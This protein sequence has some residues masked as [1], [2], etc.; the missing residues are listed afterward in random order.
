MKNFLI[1]TATAVVYVIL[2][3]GCTILGPTSAY[4]FFSLVAMACT[5]EFCNLMNRQY[6]AAI[7]TPIVAF[8]SVLLS[9]TM[10]LSITSQSAAND[11]HMLVL[12]GI[13]ILFLLIG[14]LYRQ[15][16]NPL[17]NWSLSLASQFYVALPFAMLP[18]IAV[19]YDAYLGTPE[20]EWIY[21]LAL[22]I[23]L[24]MSDTGAYLVGSLLGRY[25]PYKLFPRISPNK[26]W[27]GSIGGAILTLLAA[28]I[29]YNIRPADHSLFEWIGF[30]LVVVCFGTW[31]DLVESLLKRQLGIK[32]SGNALPGH[33]G[34]LDRF[35][36][37]LLAIPA[38]VLY[39]LA[40]A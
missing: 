23:F 15:A 9:S 11:M 24:W 20:Y 13:T 35:D 40:I 3:V 26:S 25:I 38:S 28:Y 16:P 32:D 39:F 1:R 7:N 30:A 33:G 36:S 2:L 14:E 10:W 18:L 31:G 5:W 37:A 22:F 4:I 8:A 19:R 17:K 6:D 29:I 21:P 34:F 27:V 12:Y